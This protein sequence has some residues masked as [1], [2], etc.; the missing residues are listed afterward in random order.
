MLDSDNGNKYEEAERELLTAAK[1]Y[2]R[3]S[4]HDPKVHR[5]PAATEDTWNR[6]AIGLGLRD[7][8]NNKLPS[9]IAA[10]S[11]TGT[12]RVPVPVAIGLGLGTGFG[13][14]HILTEAPGILGVTSSVYITYNHQQQLGK[15]KKQQGKQPFYG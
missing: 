5:Y 3:S 10:D 2:M 15:D 7:I 1:R 14:M 4:P 13:K 6:E 9:F 11:P 8:R 12:N